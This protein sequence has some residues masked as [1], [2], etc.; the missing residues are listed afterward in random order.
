MSC[1][2][3]KFSY[4]KEHSNFCSC[5]GLII[6]ET[7]ESGSTSEAFGVSV[8]ATTPQNKPRTRINEKSL[9]IQKIDL[10][11]I[12]SHKNYIKNI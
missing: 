10:L 1:D 8:L 11:K 12:I 4:F 6:L 7:R 2:N 3:K 5:L 9:F